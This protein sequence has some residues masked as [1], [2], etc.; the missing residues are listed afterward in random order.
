MSLRQLHAHQKDIMGLLGKAVLDALRNPSHS[1]PQLVANLVYEIPKQLNAQMPAFTQGLGIVVQ[2]G[3]VFVHQTP[4][5][6]I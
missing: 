3:G 1:E 4:K 2:A 6:E 5:V